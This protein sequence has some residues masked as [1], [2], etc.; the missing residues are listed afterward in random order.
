M[1]GLF[2]VVGQRRRPRE[3][4]TSATGGEGVKRC[5][6]QPVDPFPESINDATVWE[7]LIRLPVASLAKYKSVSKAWRATISDPV[8]VRAHLQCSKQKQQSRNP[9]SFLI[10]PQVLLGPGP[11]ER[12]STNVRFYQ[13]RLEDDTKSSKAK[14]A[15]AELIYGRYVQPGEFELV[16]FMAHCDGLVLLPTNTKAYIF[17]PMTQDSI[18]LPASKR[19]KLKWY[20]CLPIGFG[21]DASTGKY[22]VARSF[23]RSR[24]YDPVDIVKMGM[25]VYTINGEEGK[26]R[27][28]A[29]DPPYPILHSQTATHQSA[30]TPQGLLRFSLEDETFG[31]TPLLTNTYPQVEDEDVFVTELDGELCATFFSEVVRRVLIFVTPDVIVPRWYCRY[32]INIQEQCYPMASL[33][34]RGILMRGG[35]GL[36]RYNLETGRFEEDG[37]FAM[38][39]IRFLGP[40]EDTF[41]RAWQDVY[42]Y[43]LIPYTESF[44]PV[45]RKARS[46]QA[47]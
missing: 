43:Q 37:E 24:K 12:F 5:K 32:L 26:W 45:T 21:L 2:V 38:N 25:E 6:G 41:G 46:Q 34:S 17:N 1:P 28:T 9:A 16:C 27:E 15:E 44:V 22:K 36:F 20:M 19:N 42:Y 7:I 18:A 14:A 40:C 39:D 23:Y 4:G 30:T 13:L 3:H 47:L 31:V 35:D 33:G 29:V 10:A 11:P 8:F